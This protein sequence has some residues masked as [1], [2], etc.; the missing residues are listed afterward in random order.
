MRGKHLPELREERG[1]LV[2]SERVRLLLCVRL[3]LA[4]VEA[5]YA[6]GR[7]VRKRELT[8]RR[9]HHDSQDR[10]PAVR[11]RRRVVPR[12]DEL[13]HPDLPR[14]DVRRADRLHEEIAEAGH[15]EARL[16]P[17]GAANE[18]LERVTSL[19]TALGASDLSELHLLLQELRGEFAES[20]LR[21]GR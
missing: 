11:G 4:D 10:Q 14:V 15:E 17:L 9:L 13:R 20:Q 7:E 21:T 2:R 6:F 5:R 1:E 8:L 18:V 19:V 3:V 16:L 12:R